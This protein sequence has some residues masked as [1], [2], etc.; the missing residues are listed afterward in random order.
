MPTPDH[1]AHKGI[2]FCIENKLMNGISESRFNPGGTLTRAE[3][4]TILYRVEGS[5]AAEY[6][7]TFK[8]VKE[9]Q[10]YT[11]AIEWAAANGI[12][13]GVGDGSSFAPTDTI[14]REQIATILYRYT[15]S[16]EVKGNLSSFPDS[17]KVSSYAVTAMV[18]AVE[19]GIITG[20]TAN[21]VTYINPL[22]S[23]ARE[24]IAAIIMRYLAAE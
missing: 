7:G 18:W 12:V 9:G 5:P 15:G 2:D 22:N 11:A 19:E 20:A 6:V 21:N 4:V 16:P 3:L 24:Q 1:W 13:N 17:A 23:A 8:D 14:T 10:W